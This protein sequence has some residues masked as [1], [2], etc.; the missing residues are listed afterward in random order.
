MDTPE[1]LTLTPGICSS[2][3]MAISPLLNLTALGLKMMVSS[4]TDIT[5]AV[6]VSTASESMMLEGRNSTMIL[7][8]PAFTF[9][10]RRI[11]S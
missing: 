10:L 7:F 3:S 11:S 9:M 5:V 8:S 6:S 1:S 4:L 2:R